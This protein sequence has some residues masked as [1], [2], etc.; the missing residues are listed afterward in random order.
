[1]NT[2]KNFLSSG[3]YLIDN[4]LHKFLEDGSSIRYGDKS[5]V[6][7]IEGTYLVLV[8]VLNHESKVIIYNYIFYPNIF[9]Y[10][11]NYFLFQ[12]QD[13]INSTLYSE[14]GDYVTILNNNKFVDNRLQLNENS[15]YLSN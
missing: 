2:Y 5:V 13:F 1:M 4:K 9:G 8:R 10:A 3:L 11:L 6:K 15:E 12:K 7:D 14:W